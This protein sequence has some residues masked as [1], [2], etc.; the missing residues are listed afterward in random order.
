MILGGIGQSLASAADC[1]MYSL[2]YDMDGDGYIS[3]MEWGNFTCAGCD[4]DAYCVTAGRRGG[5]QQNTFVS[6]C[7]D[8]SG[9]SLPGCEYGFDWLDSP[10]KLSS[11]QASAFYDRPST[12]GAAHHR[13]LNQG[14]SE[15]RSD[16]SRD[17]FPAG[18]GRLSPDELWTP[19]CNLFL[20][21][22]SLKE[23]DPHM[24]LVVFLPA[25]L[26]ESACF[27]IDMGIFLKQLPQVCTGHKARTHAATSP[28]HVPP[29]LTRA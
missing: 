5:E 14:F 21:M 27:G 8:G 20:D 15:S 16:S 29:P 23:I 12:S 3:R 2:K 1:P 11:M 28:L 9:D 6:S 17:Q 13:A 26:F 10:W 19:R 24:M 22:I 7:N 4:A 18:D 25:L